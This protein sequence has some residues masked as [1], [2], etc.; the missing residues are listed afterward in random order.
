LSVPSKAVRFLPFG[1]SSGIHPALGFG[2][3][4]IPL[5]QRALEEAQTC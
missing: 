1:N 3:N 2:R 4:E 5:R